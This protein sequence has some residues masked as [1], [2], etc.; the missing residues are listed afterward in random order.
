MPAH[1]AVCLTPLPHQLFTQCPLPL[2]FLHRGPKT[3]RSKGFFPAGPQL[4]R[5]LGNS[6]ATHFP[7]S[8]NTLPSGL[9][10]TEPP[11]LS[12]ALTILPQSFTGCS[13]SSS[14]FPTMDFSHRFSLSNLYSLLFLTEFIHLGDFKQTFFGKPFPSIYF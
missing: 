4:P 11:Y 12:S 7:T 2:V 10:V 9:H 3:A 1:Q 6:E 8:E 13:S 14:H 5:P